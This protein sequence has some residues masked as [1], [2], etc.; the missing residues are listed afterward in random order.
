MDLMA[1]LST[2]LYKVLHFVW[3]CLLSASFFIVMLNVVARLKLLFSCF[4]S[5]TYLVK[6][7][8][9]GRKRRAFDHKLTLDFIWLTFVR[10]KWT[11]FE[12]T[13]VQTFNESWH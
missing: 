7:V 4:Y 11:K 13:Y 5:A 6:H 8:L 2:N 12:P 10:A 3:L 1:T 9:V